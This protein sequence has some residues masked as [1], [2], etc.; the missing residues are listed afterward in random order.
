MVANASQSRGTAGAPGTETL[1]RS[2]GVGVWGDKPHGGGSCGSGLLPW[3]TDLVL[4][5]EL[6]RLR[7]LGATALRL[8]STVLRV[9]C[10]K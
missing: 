7:V 10:Y 6:F 8:D 2:G 1:C 9:F 5:S 4:N 3:C